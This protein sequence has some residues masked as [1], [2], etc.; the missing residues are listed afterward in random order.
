MKPPF[1]Y[2]GGKQTVAHQITE[3]LFPPHRHYIEPFAGSLAVLL[4]KIPAKIETV[5]DLNGEIVNFWRILRDHPEELQRQCEA[6]PFSRDEYEIA[7]NTDNCTDMERARRFW[8]RVEQGFA[9]T[10]GKTGWRFCYAPN[11]LESRVWNHARRMH[12]I[13]ER[14]RNVQL[15]NR[16]AIELIQDAGKYEDVLIYA[17]PPYLAVTRETGQYMNEMQTEEEHRKLAKVLNECICKVA[18]SGYDSDLY[19]ELYGE[20]YRYEISTQTGTAKRGERLRT[21]ILWTNYQ[22]DLGLL[23]R[24]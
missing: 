17:D 20:W 1:Q 10:G 7:K 2:F 4:A 11:N 14:I 13:A 24:E 6:T 19:R 8:V 22:P 5:N 12:P 16:D 9:H 23:D 18:L 15:E 21:E 3:Q